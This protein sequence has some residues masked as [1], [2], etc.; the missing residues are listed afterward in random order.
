MRL[1]AFFLT[2]CRHIAATP[3]ST[4]SEASRDGFSPRPQT[5]MAQTEHSVKSS[6]EIFNFVLIYVMESHFN[7]LITD[8]RHIW[9]LKNKLYTQE[10]L[11]RTPLQNQLSVGG[12]MSLGVAG[13]KCRFV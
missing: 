5:K 11:R 9:D 4:Q 6:E 10:T 13:G 1:R 8:K 2:R 3:G 7:D 12:A